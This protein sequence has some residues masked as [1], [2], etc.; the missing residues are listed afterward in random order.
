MFLPVVTNRIAVIR[1]LRAYASELGLSDLMGNVTAQTFLQ[2]NGI[3]ERW[4]QWTRSQCSTCGQTPD[5]CS[6]FHPP[7]DQIPANLTRDQLL[8]GNVIGVESGRIEDCPRYTD[9]Q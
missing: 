1:M 9:S 3:L 4:D 7:D 6:F 2:T 8:T 5:S